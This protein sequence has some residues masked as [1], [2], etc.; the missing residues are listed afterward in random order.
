MAD[1]KLTTETYA[2]VVGTLKEIYAETGRADLEGLLKELGE[3]HRW[4]IVAGH[5][6]PEGYEDWRAELKAAAF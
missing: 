5:T 4:G 6:T 1:K 3:E 2:R